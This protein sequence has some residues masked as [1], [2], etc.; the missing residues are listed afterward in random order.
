[1]IIFTDDPKWASEQKIFESDQFVVSEGT[2]SYHDLY[3]MTRDS[4]FIIANSTYSWW[5]AWLANHGRVISTSKYGLV[6]TTNIN[7][8]KIFIHPIG[9]S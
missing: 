8:S 5:G 9:K 2:G 7:H 1:M 4:D 6:L 3:L